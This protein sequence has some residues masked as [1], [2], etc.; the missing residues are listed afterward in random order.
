MIV[1][2]LDDP[3][4]PAARTL[5]TAASLRVHNVS[6]VRIGGHSGRRYSLLPNEPV[7]LHEG[8]GIGLQPGEPDVVLLS[9]R[10]RTLVIQRRFDRDAV[11]PEIERV[12]MSFEFSR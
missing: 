8:L 1:N 3:L 7:S 6:R 5:E 4:A 2:A 9:V 10:H 12:V 11:R